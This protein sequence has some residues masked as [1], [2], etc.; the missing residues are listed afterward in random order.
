MAKS[1]S[2]RQTKAIHPTRN[3]RCFGII[4][5]GLTVLGLVAFGCRFAYIAAG[6]KIDSANLSKYRQKVVSKSTVLKAKRGSIY[7]R[8]GGVIAE[9]SNTYTIYAVVDHNYVSG[10]KKLYV[11]D[12]AKTAKVLAKYLPLSVAKI[13]AILTPKNSHTFQVEFG[14]AGTGLSLATKQAIQAEKLPGINFTDS[15][16]RL[17]PNGIFASHVIGLAQ[18]AV[19]ASDTDQLVGVMGL[20]KQFNSILKGT[21]GYRSSQTDAYGYQLPESKV[22][23]KAAV[24][25]GSIYTTI[26]P[27]LQTYLET[28]MTNVATKYQ[29]K[30]LLAVLEDPK[31]GE[32]LA[33]SQRPTFDPSTG[34]GMSSMWRDILV[35]DNYEPGSVMKMFT[36][37]SAIQ[38]GNYHPNQYYKSGT[39]KVADTTIRDWST[40]MNGTNWGTIPL[41]QAFPRSSNV[42][43]V[44]I[45]QTMGAT[46]FSEYLRKFGFGQQTG[47]ALPSETS[48]TFDFGS[49]LDSAMASFGQ[50]IDVN[51]MQ[52]M[53]A[54]TAIANRGEMVKPRIISKIVNKQGKT[55]RYGKQV[56]NK[57]ISADT[58][59]QVISAMKEVVNAS[60]GTGAAYKMPGVDLAVKTGTA[61]IASSNGGGYLNG[62]SNY[63]FSVMGMAPAKNPKYVLYIAMKQPQKL[64]E[65]AE[66]IMAQ[67]FKPMMTRALALDGSNSVASTTDE[68]ATVPN[69]TNDALA[70][71]QQKL[72]NAGFKAA[73]VGT[74]T[75]VVQQ[76]PT[77]GGNAL[78]NAHVVLLTNGAM[79]MPDV[80]G[81]SKSDVLKLQQLTGK[82]FKLTGSGYATQQSLKAGALLG[83]QSVTIQFAQQ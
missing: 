16:S 76:L 46:V 62:N 19:H 55:T 79:T 5:M 9:D 42:G 27:S 30:S 34:E 67:I 20:E 31:T 52:L 61:Q 47:I 80:S 15:P 35:E 3:R 77:S 25:G 22:K 63:I 37:A 73:V 7:D 12:K 40:S 36:L 38:S 81:W 23:T 59:E 6:G 13:Q 32:I 18:P 39:V 57:P 48:G 72:T 44:K 49:Y 17:Y 65:A 71:A 28:L 1:T 11:Q 75:R 78:K 14:T 26:D 50:S 60:Y 69:V 43:M 29:P 21:N 66:S 24:N 2:K 51:A 82:N 64:T 45:E 70:T 56:V 8:D 74:G 58:A 41:S 54:S 53:Q 83:D 68:T 33:A 10:K 4:L